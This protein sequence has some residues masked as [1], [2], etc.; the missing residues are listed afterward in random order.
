[1][2]R[3]KA[4]RWTVR[5]DMPHELDPQ[6]ATDEQLGL[7]DEDMLQMIDPTGSYTLDVGWYPAATRSGRFI[8]RVVRSEDWDRPLAQLE[9]PNM[10]IVWRWLKQQI[11]EID[12]RVGQIGM[13]TD[14][15][16]LFVYLKVAKSART[17]KMR[18][19]ARK[20]KVIPTFLMTPSVSDPM[21][22]LDRVYSGQGPAPMTTN[23]STSATMAVGL[24]AGL[25]LAYAA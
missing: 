1:M 10:K 16:G 25:P 9:T 20:P 4:P 15:V 19:A 6:T 18:P 11:D 5:G 2:P 7:L 8:C 24:G 21:P 23:P 12:L 14:N 3:P 17:K 13:F 22:R